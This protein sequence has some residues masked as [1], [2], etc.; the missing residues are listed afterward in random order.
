MFY[1]F[2]FEHIWFKEFGVQRN[3]VTSPTKRTLVRASVRFEMNVKNDP[4]ES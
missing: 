4:P 2:T 1:P 3:V